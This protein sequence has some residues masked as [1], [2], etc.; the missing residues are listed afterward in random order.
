MGHSTVKP[1]MLAACWC[2]L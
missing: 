2:L 1:D